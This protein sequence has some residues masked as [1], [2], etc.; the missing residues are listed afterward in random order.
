[1]GS[2]VS[3]I[4]ELATDFFYYILE[5]YDHKQ[6]VAAHILA[7]TS[8]QD[9]CESFVFCNSKLHPERTLY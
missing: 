3:D 2:F 1:M 5:H 6:N 7:R 9:H 4:K 8:E